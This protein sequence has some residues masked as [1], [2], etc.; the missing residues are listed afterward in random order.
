MFAYDFCCTYH[1][2]AL[3]SR[4][5]RKK[6][7]P[8]SLSLSPS[9]CLC[10]ACLHATHT[11]NKSARHIRVFSPFS[12]VLFFNFGNFVIYAHSRRR[13]GF[14]TRST[15]S[16]VDTPPCKL[17]FIPVKVSHDLRLFQEVSTIRSDWIS[18]KEADLRKRLNQLR[19][20]IVLPD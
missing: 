9:V 2:Q 14:C 19:R 1:W 13:N 8:N 7:L 6:T 16:Y 15:F 18:A 11:G 10:L 3:I 4:C 17:M 12:R 5:L 20:R